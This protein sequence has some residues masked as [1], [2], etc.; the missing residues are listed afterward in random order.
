MIDTKLN[1]SL[2]IM[3]A[4]S[5]VLILI[6]CIPIIDFYLLNYYCEKDGAKYS[7]KYFTNTECYAGNHIFYAVLGGILGFM[8]ILYVFLTTLLLFEN[9]PDV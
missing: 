9:R 2:L 8:L 1:F 7:H 4:I 3:Q 6:L 5:E